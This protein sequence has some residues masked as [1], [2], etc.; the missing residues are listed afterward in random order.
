[1]TILK[2]SLFTLFFGL[3]G[4]SSGL[5]FHIAETERKCFIEEIPDETMV[6]GKYIIKM[7]T[8]T[9]G[10]ACAR[11]RFFSFFQILYRSGIF[12]LHSVAQSQSCDHDL[13]LQC[14]KILQHQACGMIVNYAASGVIY[15]CNGVLILKNPLKFTLPGSS[16]CQ[17]LLALVRIVNYDCMLRSKLKR[18]LR[19]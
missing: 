6:T 19:L 4:L 9:R 12:F 18:N 13:Q 2:I 1:M 7:F 8:Y 11:L 14:C 16:L 3:F 10:Q 15:D 5:Y 17:P